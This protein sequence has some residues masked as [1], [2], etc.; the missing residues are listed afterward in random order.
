MNSINTFKSFALLLLISLVT[1][2][3]GGGGGGS[4]GSE[5]NTSNQ[6]T[7]SDSNDNSTGGGA[8]ASYASQSEVETAVYVTNADFDSYP[9]FSGKEEAVSKTIRHLVHFMDVG[10]REATQQVP[11]SLEEDNTTSLGETVVDWRTINEFQCPTGEIALETEYSS[12]EALDS[13]D[14]DAVGNIGL[15]KLKKCEEAVGDET[16]LMDGSILTYYD[17]SS[18]RTIKKYTLETYNEVNTHGIACEYEADVF[19][20]VNNVDGKRCGINEYE[21]YVEVKNMNIT[22]ANGSG[23]FRIYAADIY[24]DELGGAVSVSTS[25]VVVLENDKLVAPEGETV[26]IKFETPAEVLI[27]KVDDTGLVTEIL[28]RETSD[29]DYTNIGTSSGLNYYTGLEDD[30]SIP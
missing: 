12:Q 16:F 1:A 17:S 18:E 10:V 29:V 9:D 28:Y 3:G 22:G 11:N 8:E 13:R 4:T 2:C 7:N 5:D 21:N 26:S 19:G 27:F 6:Q 24:D 25:D 30:V 15:A 14:W 20:A 23:A